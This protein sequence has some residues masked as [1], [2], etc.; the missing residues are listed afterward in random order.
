MTL[1]GGKKDQIEAL[2]VWVVRKISKTW[3]IKFNT[4]ANEKEIVLMNT[5]KKGKFVVNG[6]YTRGSKYRLQYNPAV[7]NDGTD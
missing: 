2:E 5:L 6:L 1:K 4:G 3:T 7:N